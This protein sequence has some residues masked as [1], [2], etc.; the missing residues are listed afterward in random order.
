VL[1]KYDV[2]IVNFA[3]C[4]MVGH[5]GVFKAVLK[6][7]H[8]VDVCVGDV[9]DA[10]LA[11]GGV[12]LVTADHGNAEEMELPDGSPMTAHTI[13]DVPFILIGCGN[14]Q[15]RS[16]GMLADIAPTML[17][18]MGVPKPKEMELAKGIIFDEFHKKFLTNTEGVVICYGS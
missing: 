9:V 8:T 18:I 2:I 3:N 13:N 6:A 10:V 1:K 14:P 17:E 7:V 12:A 5:T 4:D 16:D 11:A 15:L